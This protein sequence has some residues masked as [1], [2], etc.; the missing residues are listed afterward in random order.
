MAIQ[1]KWRDYTF[2]VSTSK[3]NS[4]E[5]LSQSIKIKEKDSESK[6]TKRELKEMSFE[7]VLMDALGANPQSE[8]AAWESVI[9]ESGILYLHGRR[10]GDEMILQSVSLGE[11]TLDGFGRIRKCKLSITLKE[12]N[13]PYISTS[14][15]KEALTQAQKPG[16]TKKKIKGSKKT[17][18]AGSW[19][20][21][22]GTYFADGEPI[23]S[24]YAKEIYTVRNVKGDQAYIPALLSWV[25]LSALSLVK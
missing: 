25:Y 6:K 13:T 2:S 8:L 22:V 11:V 12:A 3:V 7:I 21:L 24:A 18:K 23:P 15:P 4:I 17:I 16:K 1:G 10:F 20:K 19:V 9:G 14:R 5:G